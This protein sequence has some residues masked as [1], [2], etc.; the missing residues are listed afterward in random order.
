MNLKKAFNKFDKNISIIY[1]N[2]NKIYSE[3]EVLELKNLFIYQRKLF[4]S[5]MLF[6]Q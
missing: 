3:N 5:T 2:Y 6:S 1:R 4:I